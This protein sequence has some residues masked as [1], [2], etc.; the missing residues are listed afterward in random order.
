MSKMSFTNRE[1]KMKNSVKWVQSI[2]L[3]FWF[4]R[5]L[6]VT[7]Y[8]FRN[9]DIIIMQLNEIYRD[10][11]EGSMKSLF[12][13]AAVFSFALDL[14]QCVYGM[15][16]LMSNRL[17]NIQI[18]NY[19]MSMTLVTRVFLTY[20]SVLNMLLLI[21]KLIT[22]MYVRYV[23]SCLLNSMIVLQ[24]Y[25]FRSMEVNGQQRAASTPSSS[26]NSSM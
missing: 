3:L 9:K 10:Q 21:V 1:L 5:F 16:A 20:L 19:T 6:F 13:G 8:F 26:Q 11:T 15:Y 4:L 24:G 22:W 17:T 14:I 12:E 25:G 7:I 2:M 18:F 23:M